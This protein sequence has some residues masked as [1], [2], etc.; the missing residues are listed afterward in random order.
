M[1]DELEKIKKEA[2]DYYKKA[3]IVLSDDEIK[4][5]EIADM[6][7]NDFKRTGLVLVVYVNNDR[8]CAK[9][10]VLFPHQTCPEHR[11]PDHAGQE[12]KQETFRC[13]YGTAYLY[14]EGQRTSQP[15]ASP[16]EGDE[17]YYTVFHEIIL[18]PGQQYTISKDTLL[19]KILY[20]GFKLG[21]RV[22]LFLNFLLPVMMLPMYL[23]IRGLNELTKI[24]EGLSHAENG[25]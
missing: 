4:N 16:P 22:R 9:E 25:Q 17:S 6:G 24:K 12:G 20:I 15:I 21:K 3:G 10:M 7:L 13:R 19:V 23:L 18:K 2:L 5:M 8:Y 1:K 11:H 14:I